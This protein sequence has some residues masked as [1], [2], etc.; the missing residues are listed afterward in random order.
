MEKVILTN[1]C[2]IYNN[3]KILVENRLKNDWP[4]LT[5]PGGHIESGE[6]I[7]SSVIREIKEETNLDI[8]NPEFCGIKEWIEKDV[9]HICYLFRTSEFSGNLISSK[10][11]EVFWVKLEDLNKYPYS[12]D[13]DILVDYF[14]KY[15]QD[16]KILYLEDQKNK[17]CNYDS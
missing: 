11:G 6:S 12:T 7:Y 17:Y 3:D 10:E 9:R 4:G 14:T 8:K 16:S 5:F 15:N 13:F 2:M 1:M